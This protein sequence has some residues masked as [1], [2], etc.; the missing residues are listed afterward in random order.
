MMNLAQYF[1]LC[2]E[3]LSF[4][5]GHSFDSNF[6]QLCNNNVQSRLAIAQ[7]IY[8][9]CE[10]KKTNMKYQPGHEADHGTQ[11]HMSQDQEDWIPKNRL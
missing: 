10:Q 5:L 1:H 8:I 4:C 2:H 3:L 9:E 6:L 7:K 11:H